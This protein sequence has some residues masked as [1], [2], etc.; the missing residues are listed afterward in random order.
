[1]AQWLKSTAASVTQ[2][3]GLIRCSDS[4]DFSSIKVGDI[5]FLAGQIWQVLRGTKQDA[6][7][8]STIELAEPWPYAD[9]V[10]GSLYIIRSTHEL[11]RLATEIPNLTRA[12][13]DVL[14][15][16]EEV[17]TSPEPTVTITVGTDPITGEPLTINVRPW[18]NVLD[19][20]SAVEHDA[21]Q[22]A[23]SALVSKNAAGASASAAAASEQ[24]ASTSETNAAGSASSALASKNTATSKATE[25]AGSASSAL[26]SKNAAAG[27][28]AAAATSASNALASE[29]AA[30]ASE[31]AASSSEAA[32]L[33][34]Q[35]AAKVSETA[36]DADR[37]SAQTY[38]NAARDARDEAATSASNALAS[39]NAAATSA[40]NASASA[41]DARVSK[42]AAEA[43]AAMATGAM[44]EMGGYNASSGAFPSKPEAPSAPGTYRSGFWKITG[45]GTLGGVAYGVGDSL[46]YSKEL[47]GWYK[48][49]NTESVTS[50]NGHQGVVSLDHADVGAAPA[51]HSHDYLPTTGGTVTSDLTVTGYVL[52]NRIRARSGDLLALFAGESVSQA[53]GL[54]GEMV[55]LVGEAGAKVISSPDNWASGWAGRHEATLLNNSGN[56]GF[57]NG[58]YA[59][60]FYEN[61][62]ALATKYAAA[63]HSH[64]LAIADVTGL[65]TALDGKS[66][67][68]SHPY[69]A[70][71]HTHSIANITNLQTVLDGKS[72]THSHPYAPSSHS[73]GAGELPSATTS[74]K[75]VV[76]L[77]SSTGST[78]TTLAATASAVKAAYD[79]ANHT[80]PYAAS[81]HTHSYLPLAGGVITGTTRFND[82]VKLTLGTGNDASLFCN[83]SHAYL[84]LGTGIGNFYIR[85]GTA[86]RFTF[87]DA[88]HF[89][90]T[91]NVTAYQT[92]DARIKR[93]IQPIQGA[94]GK[95]MGLTAATYEKASGF[96]MDD[97]APETGLIAQEVA[98]AV[99]GLV[100]ENDEGILAIRT[101]GHELI[102]LLVGAIQ[103]Q[104]QQ[105]AE[106]QLHLGAHNGAA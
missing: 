100:K 78:S 5:V 82:N 87:D 20:V 39:K 59:T 3:G 38:M 33:A 90:A 4:A 40:S 32:A 89:S 74:A 1:M 99:D 23:D 35:N 66:A 2:G 79:K 10:D 103:E 26:S 25:A 43:A 19:S 27:S 75:G 37:V 86:T 101:G 60:R 102:A 49:D 69:A 91:G 11:V 21:K 17:L 53:T 68:H 31:L 18:Q 34:S 88:G 73:H 67:T 77:S 15:H 83:G 24:N 57:P 70:T 94:L 56:A 55:Y 44:V 42:D 105:I 71:S 13:K 62:V 6:S 98:L 61:S 22:Y 8:V 63:G 41:D 51:S 84:D 16:F 96:G 36:A 93:N 95:V 92:S 48:I 28:A 47:N 104:Q 80:H 58:V 50:V 65:Q 12:T 54:S 81:S 29:E 76:Q 14:T 46:V 85:D 106:L 64:D 72:A 7:G 9:V 97:Y 45:A 30:A 52:A